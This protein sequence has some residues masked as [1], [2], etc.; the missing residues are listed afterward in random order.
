MTIGSPVA[1]AVSGPG[2]AD[3]YA[4]CRLS[5]DQ[6]TDCPCP[7]SGE[8][9][10]ETSATCVASDPSGCTTQSPDWLPSPPSY[11]IHFPSGD[12][13]SCDARDLSPPSRVAFCVARSMTQSCAYGR[14]GSSRI[15]TVYATVRPSGERAT[16]PTFRKRDRS[17]LW[18]PCA[19]RGGVQPAP[20][21]SP[22]VTPPATASVVATT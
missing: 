5:G 15:T 14:P 4:I 20:A 17:P 3:T 9:D 8:F 1:S 18:S 22:A 11:A 19:A 16:C 21:A 7:G 6:V 12:Q 2:V 13:C 10:P